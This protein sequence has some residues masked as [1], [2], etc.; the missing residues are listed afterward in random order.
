[1]TDSQI[2]VAE[3]YGI[4]YQRGVISGGGTDAWS[5]FMAGK[6]VAAGGINIPSRY[7]HTAVSTVHMDDLLSTTEFIGRYTMDF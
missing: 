1:M 5:A 6:G 7:I 2:A 4:P 3:K